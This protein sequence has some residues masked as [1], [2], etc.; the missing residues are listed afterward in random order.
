MFPLVIYLGV[1]LW[2]K[3]DGLETFEDLETSQREGCW[4]NPGRG[5]VH[6]GG[7]YDL[8]FGGDELKASYYGVALATYLYQ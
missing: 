3:G 6:T 7:F 2:T 8:L 4:V 5:P 1:N